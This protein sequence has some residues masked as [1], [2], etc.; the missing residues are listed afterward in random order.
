MFLYILIFLINM[1]VALFKKDNRI[2]PFFSFIFLGILAGKTD[3]VFNVD[4]LAYYT[5]YLRTGSFGYVSRFEWLYV[6][7]EKIFVKLGFQYSTFRLCIMV[8]G[9][10]LLFVGLRLIIKNVSAFYCLFAMTVFPFEATQ[11]RTFL[12]F[13]IVT[14]AVGI[15]K[16]STKKSTIIGFLLMFVSTGFH[17]TGYLF[18]FSLILM[19]VFLNRDTLKI[20]FSKLMPILALIMT[21]MFQGLGL[22]HVIGGLVSKILG[23]VSTNQDA[24]QR[25]ATRFNTLGSANLTLGYTLAFSFLILVIYNNRNLSTMTD[26]DT[27][28]FN[29]LLNLRTIISVTCIGMPLMTISADY[30]R[31]IREGM[32]FLFIYWIVSFENSQ[33]KF[34]SRDIVYIFMGFVG[35]GAFIFLFYFTGGN[36]QFTNSLPYLIQ[37]G[38]SY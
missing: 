10:I 1:I 5:D 22:S 18:L 37:P 13:S 4:T 16:K 19:K 24:V 34:T 36:V 23:V 17:S 20:G 28:Q 9:F 31:I 33:V 38:T 32:L 11:I 21:I 29:F 6:F 12:M 2:V 25:L 26:I 7:I 8:T 27:D 14:L 15:L 3:T 35:I 30:M